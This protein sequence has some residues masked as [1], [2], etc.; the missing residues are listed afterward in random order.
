MH[1]MR[2]KPAP[3]DALS[4]KPQMRPLFETL[5]EFFEAYNSCLDSRI[6]V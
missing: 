6:S 1:Y 2:F 5:D 3:F 4:E